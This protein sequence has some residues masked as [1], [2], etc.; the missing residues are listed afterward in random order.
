MKSFN[1]NDPVFYVYVLLDPR[2][3]G[4]FKYGRYS[5][6]HEPFYVGKGKDSR[7]YAHKLRGSL[8]LQKKLRK[9]NA[10]GYEHIIHV[11][12]DNIVESKAYELEVKLIS[13]IGRKIEKEGPL[14]NILPGGE[15]SVGL[16]VSKAGLR[17][18]AKSVKRDWDNLTQE[19]YDARRKAM[20]DGRQ[21]MSPERKEQFK[22]NM[23]RSRKVLFESERGDEL[24]D[25]I[26]SNTYA[27]LARETPEQKEARYRK[28]GR[29]RLL[30][31]MIAL[32]DR[33]ETFIVV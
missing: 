25:R 5:F 7:A 19:E 4:N 18:R 24:R 26:R 6:E 12:K 32:L 9:I 16:V 14:T 31:K 23:R 30:N 15:T 33:H 3:P 29:T 21:S 17:R 28:Q 8:L 10:D 27:Q 20:S 1:P 22:A 13:S 2:R 11:Y